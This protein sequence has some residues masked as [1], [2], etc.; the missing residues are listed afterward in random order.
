MEPSDDF[1][2]HPFASSDTARAT[3]RYMSRRHLRHCDVV[4]PQQI[5]ERTGVQTN[6]V[7]MWRKR[8]VMPDV[9]WQIS[10]VPLWCWTEDIVPWLRADPRR[11]HMAPAED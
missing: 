2:L 4:G 3:M 1:A 10:D 7:H 9:R 8:G 5:A 6:T 11:A